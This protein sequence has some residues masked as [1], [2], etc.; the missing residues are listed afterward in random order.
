[1]A[2]A[3]YERIAEDLRGRITSRDIKPGG[4]LPS[5]LELRDDTTRQGTPSLTRSRSSR[6]RAWSRPV[7]GKAGSHAQDRAVRELHRLG[8]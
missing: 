3:A 4:Q 6:T 7:Q 8:R 5:E 1:M 2:V